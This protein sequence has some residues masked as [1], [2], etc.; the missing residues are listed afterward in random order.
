MCRWR[1][2]G[3]KCLVGSCAPRLYFKCSHK[4]CQAKKHVQVGPA[5]ALE[6][7][8]HYMLCRSCSRSCGGAHLTNLDVLVCRCCWRTQPLWQSATLEHTTTTLWQRQGA[9]RSD[10]LLSSLW[11]GRRFLVVTFSKLCC[12]DSMKPAPICCSYARVPNAH[13]KVCPGQWLCRANAVFMSQSEVRLLAQNH[14]GGPCR[15]YQRL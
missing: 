15:P 13:I 7:A 1:K 8:K 11:A 10:V 12:H 9:S 5:V 4:A 6:A 14:I 2:Y 3:E